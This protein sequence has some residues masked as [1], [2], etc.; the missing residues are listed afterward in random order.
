MNKGCN[1][2]LLNAKNLHCV[3]VEH[4]INNNN[5]SNSKNKIKYVGKKQYFMN[6][7]LGELPPLS[8]D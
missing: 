3:I 5:N 6:Y 2:I 8:S 4:N 1:M 7:S